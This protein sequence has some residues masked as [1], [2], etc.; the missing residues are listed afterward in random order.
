[1]PCGPSAWV[2]PLAVR[3]IGAPTPS[4]GELHLLSL[5]HASSPAVP[6]EDH[7]ARAKEHELPL[8][9][10]QTGLTCWGAKNKFCSL[11]FPSAKWATHPYLKGVMGLTGD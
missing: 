7:Q 11:P 8:V 1:M 9:W 6:H 10:V 3:F 5:G 4:D 2:S